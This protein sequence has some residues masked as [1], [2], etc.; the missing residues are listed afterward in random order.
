MRVCIVTPYDLSHEGGVNRHARS[1]ARALLDHGHAAQVIGPSSGSVP[2]GCLSLPGVIPVRA[3]GSVAR[4]GLLV[5]PR[6]TRQH[7]LSGGYDVVHVHEPI[8]PGPARHA[9]R[10]AQVPLVATFHA[11]A[12]REV[13]L[14]R[15]LRRFAGAGLSR[16]A[17]GIAV[18][19]EAKR[20]S[21]IVY[22]GRTAIIPNGVDLSRFAGPASGGPRPGEPLEILFVGRFGERRKG[23]AH[24]LEAAAILQAQGRATRICVVGDGPVDRFAAAADRMRI[25]FLGRLPDREL[26]ERYRESHV[27]C[28][29]SLGGESF[30]M[31]LV[32]AMAA[33]CPVVASDLPGYA[34]AAGGA[35]CLVRPAA[36]GDLAEALWRVGRDAEVRERLVGLGRSRADALCWSRIALRVVHVY[37]AALD[38]TRPLVLEPA[39]LPA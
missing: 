17:R 24:L 29:P 19:R 14:Q 32:E 4:I 39:P 33:G 1:L 30:G 23:F 9:L 16:I 20:F 26:A 18:S 6:T 27:F 28:A 2:E 11:S 13:P 35:A 7:L 36:P 37:E 38:E 12:E 8:V 3:N 25:R 22:R 34:E 5:S 31:V 15:L 10:F 21:R